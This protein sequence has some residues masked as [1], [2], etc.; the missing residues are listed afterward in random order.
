MWGFIQ[1]ECNY[2]FQ[3]L[4]NNFTNKYVTSKNS[5][6]AR[7]VF[8]WIIFVLNLIYQIWTIDYNAIVTVS[9][10]VSDLYE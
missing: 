4:Q 2:N 1:L 10:I 6:F 3:A 8:F 9:C 7:N 5:E